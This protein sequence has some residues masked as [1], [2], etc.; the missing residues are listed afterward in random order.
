TAALRQ[1]GGLGPEL[2][3]DHSTTL[4]MNAGGWR[5][6]HAVDAISHGDGPANFTDLVVQEFQR[7]RS[8]DTIL[9][10]HSSRHIMHLP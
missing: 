1:I 9:L 5:G 4:V 6:V 7:T 10:Q 8:L 2:A 3:E